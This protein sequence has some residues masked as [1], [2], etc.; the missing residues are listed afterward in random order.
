MD[1]GL[2]GLRSSMLFACSFYRSRDLW[3]IHEERQP[4]LMFDEGWVGSDPVSNLEAAPPLSAAGVLPNE[5]HFRSRQMSQARGTRPGYDSPAS[6][7]EGRGSADV[8]VE[9]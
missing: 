6:V 4:I 3:I 8:V 2:L 1:A 7:R 9:S 5:I